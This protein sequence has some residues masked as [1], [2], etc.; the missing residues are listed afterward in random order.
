MTAPATNVTYEL[1][2]MLRITV[3]AQTLH[4]WKWQVF[5]KKLSMFLMPSSVARRCRL[6]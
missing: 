4:R 6:L 1:L 5:A 3:I 2:H